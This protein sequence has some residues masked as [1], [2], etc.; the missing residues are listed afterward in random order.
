[1]LD[2][3]GAIHF[4][5]YA[6]YSDSGRLR[7]PTRLSLHAL[8][9]A[10]A[11]KCSRCVMIK[12]VAGGYKVLSENGKKNLGGPYKTKKEAEKRLRQVEFFK[13]RKG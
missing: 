9:P 4:V 1:M 2:R 6:T 11:S 10:L 13:H 7:S 8:C 12:K 3:A 5:V